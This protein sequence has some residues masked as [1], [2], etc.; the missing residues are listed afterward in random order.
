MTLKSARLKQWGRRFVKWLLTLTSMKAG[1]IMVGLCV[2][3]YVL[4]IVTGH[5]DNALMNFVMSIDHRLFDTMF[6]LR[7]PIPPTGEVVIVDIDEKS[8]KEL[9]QWP[10]PRTYLAQILRNLKEAGV[11][12]VGMD[13]VFAEPDRSSPRNYAKYFEELAGKKFE[14]EE[15]RLDNDVAFGDALAEEGLKVIVG[16]VFLTE[17]DGLL[18]PDVTPPC[19]QYSEPLSGLSK[20]IRPADLRSAYRPVLDIPAI[21]DNAISEGFFN[22]FPDPATEI[23]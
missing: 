3:V 22:M 7:G 20:R 1:V 2:G 19:P 17:N 8:L 5:T 4:P 18:N 12:V 6:R 11:K 10:W 21:A 13:I 14:L 16:Y 23:V 9:G 15:G